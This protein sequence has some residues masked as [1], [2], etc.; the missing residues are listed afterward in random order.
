M[1]QMVVLCAVLLVFAAGADAQANSDTTLPVAPT[2][3]LAAPAA[4]ADA[5]PLVAAE[6]R[7]LRPAL[8]AW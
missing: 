6:L 1:K 8:D 5:T 2:A 7:P 3:D 4:S